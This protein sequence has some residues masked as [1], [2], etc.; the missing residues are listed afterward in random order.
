MGAYYLGFCLGSRTHALGLFSGFA[1][2][3]CLEYEGLS[4][5]LVL[6]L[7][8]RFRASGSQ[9]LRVLGFRV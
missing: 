5:H 1:V 4:V 2:F 9:V 3:G 8:H 6:E 7:I